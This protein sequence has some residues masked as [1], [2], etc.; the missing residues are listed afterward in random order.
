MH[1]IK[2]GLR[3]QDLEGFHLPSFRFSC[4]LKETSSIRLF[5]FESIKSKCRIGVECLTQARGDTDAVLIEIHGLL[6]FLKTF[7]QGKS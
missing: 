5:A 6:T 3:L 7:C 4:K 2:P 1:Q